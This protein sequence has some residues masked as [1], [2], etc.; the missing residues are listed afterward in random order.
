MTQSTKSNSEY[1]IRFRLP[2]RGVLEKRYKRFLA[3]IRLTEDAPEHGGKKG[4]VVTAHCTNTGSMKGVCVVG[5]PAV[6]SCAENADRKLKYTWEATRPT[7]LTDGEWVGIN[8][9]NPNKLVGEALRR[10]LLPELGNTTPEA[11]L[12]T[13][14]GEAKI[15]AAT[16]LDFMLTPVKGKKPITYIEVKNVTLVEDATKPK[17]RTAYFPDSVSERGTKHLNELAALAKEGHR[18]MVLFVVQ[19]PDCGE[20]RGDAHIDEEYA[21]AL[22]MVC[23][24]GVEALAYSF[25]VDESG[26][27]L[28]ERLKVET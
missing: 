23:A 4:D 5:A 27:R 12:W 26:V 17:G 22:K 9:A 11:G 14:K 10:G 16:R 3:D 6:V 21:N 28:G 1:L 15:S 13:V 20:V 8:T 2:V 19:R 7:G 18:A 24:A 25:I